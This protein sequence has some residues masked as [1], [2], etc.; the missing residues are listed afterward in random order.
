MTIFGH[1]IDPVFIAIAV[2]V[3]YAASSFYYM[4]KL[5]GYMKEITLRIEVLSELHDSP[6]ASEIVKKLPNF[7]LAVA[8][9]SQSFINYPRAAFLAEG[10]LSKINEILAVKMD[11]ETAREL[12]EE[13]TEDGS[14]FIVRGI[15]LRKW[16]VLADTDEKKR[17]VLGA[18]STGDQ[19]EAG[20]V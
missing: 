13:A 17:E 9:L 10:F 6:E 2:V 14:N 7:L 18:S 5:S 1:Y 12:Y 15:A 3:M 8:A 20:I 11:F 19:R 16:Y 4:R